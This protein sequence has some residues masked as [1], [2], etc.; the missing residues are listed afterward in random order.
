M[1]THWR[2][3][4]DRPFLAGVGL[5]FLMFIA[6]QFVNHYFLMEY[7]MAKLDMSMLYYHYVSLL[8]EILLASIIAYFASRAIAAKSQEIEE[9]SRQKDSLTDALVHDLRQPLTAVIGGLSTIALDPGL[10]VTTRELVAIANLGAGELLGMVNDLLD[11]TRLEAGK[12]LF[13]PQPVDVADSVRRGVGS[14]AELARERDQKLS[15]DIP[16]DLPPVMGDADR[17]RRVVTN[18][19]G[20][21]IKYTP[22]GGEIAISAGAEG[23]AVVVRVSDTGP[24][25][26]QELQ[27]AIFDKFCVLHENPGHGRSST[28]LGLAFC[29][30]VVEAHGGRIWVESEA[31]RGSTFSFS[32]PVGR[33]HRHPEP[34]L[35]PADA[36]PGKDRSPGDGTRCV[37]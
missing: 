4:L 15:L 33:R 26:A 37:S 2:K 31:G 12:P 35:P 34:A 27:Q 11:I 3:N 24:G 30:M 1:R 22:A 8:V 6:W 29:R 13:Q 18:L 19:V 10:P 20:N 7:L 36:M 32:I 17:L 14:V 21:A 5:A 28:G 23:N 25:I 16:P 9:L